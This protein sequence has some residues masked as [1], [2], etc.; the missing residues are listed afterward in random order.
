MSSNNFVKYLGLKLVHLNCRSIF[1]KLDQLV[2]LYRECDIMCISETWLSSKLCNNLLHFPSKMLFRQ[3]R[4]YG[5]REVRGGGVCIY[6]D[7]KFGPYTSV[8]VPCS[9]CNSDFEILSLDITRP[10]HKHMTMVC[11]YRP[12]RGKHPSFI[13]FLEHVFKTSKSEIWILGD[14]NVDYL[15]RGDAFRQ[16]YI[17]LFKK[18]C[19]KQ[20]IDS[21]TRPNK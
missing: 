13:K 21:I 10:G 17:D 2:L 18:Y 19:L 5:H 8:N 11:I 15:N 3:D 20:Y 14:F 1:K 12:P 9:T 7:S 4:S 16:K 6:I